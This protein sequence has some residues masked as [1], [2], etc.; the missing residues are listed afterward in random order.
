MSPRRW[1]ARVEDILSAIHEIRAFVAGMSFDAFRQDNKTIRATIADF[2]IVGEAAAQMP[3]EV[4]AA[5]PEVPWAI[6]RGMRNALVH[7]YFD[8]DPKIGWETIERDLPGLVDPL[9][10]ML[11][12]RTSSPD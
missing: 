1:Q 11:E 2:I 7:A 6:M 5:H 12:G 3:T 9:R 10:A 8:V 4:V